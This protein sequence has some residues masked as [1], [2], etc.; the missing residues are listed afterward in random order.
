[1]QQRLYVAHSLKYLLFAAELNCSVVS[2]SLRPHG[3]QP[4]RL[5]CPWEFSRQESGPLQKKTA[6][7]L[8][9]TGQGSRSLRGL[10]SF[11]SGSEIK[12]PPA[13]AGDVGLIPGL[14]I[15]PGEGNG[16][17][18][19]YFFLNQVMKRHEEIFFKNYFPEV[20]LIYNV[21]FKFCCTEK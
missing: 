3:L 15:S 17:P 6:N 11:P 14:G 2:D 8:N 20:Y 10:L 9:E 12:N 16:N 13:N 5:L 18:L 1:M 19:Q 21:V 7:P 4:T